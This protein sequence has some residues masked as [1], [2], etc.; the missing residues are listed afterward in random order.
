MIF[1]IIVSLPGDCH[2]ATLLAMAFI[3][4]VLRLKFDFSKQA[5]LKI[6]F[7]IWKIINIFSLSI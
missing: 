7:I 4:Y 6:C 2:V 3:R 1:S 5:P